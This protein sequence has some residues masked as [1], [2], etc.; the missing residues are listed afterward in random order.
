MSALRIQKYY[1]IFVQSYRRNA[2]TCTSTDARHSASL[3]TPLDQRRRHH[4]SIQCS[5][6]TYA[7]PDTRSIIDASKQSHKP[8][9]MTRNNDQQAEPRASHKSHQIKLRRAARNDVDPVTSSSRLLIVTRQRKTPGRNQPHS[10]QIRLRP[11][12]AADNFMKDLQ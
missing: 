12:P 7:G 2:T 8:G 9:A 6:R 3:S 10:L 11:G 1:G 4:L 5:Y